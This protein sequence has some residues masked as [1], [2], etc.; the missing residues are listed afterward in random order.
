MVIALCVSNG[1]RHI[2]VYYLQLWARVMWSVTNRKLCGVILNTNNGLSTC[3]KG[4]RTELAFK[5]W[6]KWL[7]KVNNFSSSVCSLCASEFSGIH[8][9]AQICRFEWLRTTS[10]ILPS[11]YPRGETQN[12]F[13]VAWSNDEKYDLIHDI[14]A[15]HPIYIYQNISILVLLEHGLI[16]YVYVTAMRRF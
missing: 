2:F 8:V 5:S 9:I 7:V 3:I 16:V 11:S 14:R 13:S 4:H 6:C 10:V 15:R 1:S 12:V